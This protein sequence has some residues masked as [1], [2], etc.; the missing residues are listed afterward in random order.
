VNVVFTRRK[1]INRRAAGHAGN[2]NNVGKGKR[3]RKRQQALLRKL[4]K[5]AE[6]LISPL[7]SPP[8]RRA[9]EIFRKSVPWARL[10]T[11]FI[12]AGLAALAYYGTFR[13]HVSVE[14]YLSLNPVDPYKTQFVVKN[15]NSIFDVRNVECVCWPRRMESGNGFSIISPVPLQN[16]KHTIP[17][18]VAGDSSTVDCPPVIGGIGTYSGNVDLAEFELVVTYRQSWWPVET[19]RHAFKAVQDVNRAVHWVH[20]TPA[21]EKPMLAK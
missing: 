18:L 1:T 21:E 20:T 13:P 16:I 6:P 11:A 7:P 8:P 14:P 12:G 10:A 9:L 4:S 19:E 2:G 5:K 17:I 15:E 3:A